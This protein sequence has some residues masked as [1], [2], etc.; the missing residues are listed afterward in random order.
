MSEHILAI[1]PGGKGGHTGI[2]WLKYDKHTPPVMLDSYAIPD[3]VEGFIE[4]CLD[5]F[6]FINPLTVVCEKF[7]PRMVPGADYTPLII[8]GALQ[9]FARLHDFTVHWQPASGKNTAVPDRVLKNLGLLDPS[10]TKDHH[11]DRKEAT[12]HAV[13]WLLKKKHLPTLRAGWRPPSA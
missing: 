10:W 1:D 3:D 7:V 9:T 13:W 6:P 2:V 5:A 8:E 4:W 11:H 12:R